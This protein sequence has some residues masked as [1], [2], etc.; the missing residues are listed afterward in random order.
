MKGKHRYSPTLNASGNVT[1]LLL[2]LIGLFTGLFYAILKINILRHVNQRALQQVFTTDSV[3]DEVYH[4]LKN[5][6]T[7]KFNLMGAL[8]KT[9]S[10]ELSQI[11]SRATENPRL[12]KVGTSFSSNDLLGTWE[13]GEADTALITLDEMTFF[14]LSSEEGILTLV[15]HKKPPTIG[16]SFITRSIKVGQFTGNYGEVTCLSRVESYDQHVVEEF[17]QTA[18]SK[19]G[20][21]S[22]CD[23]FLLGGEVTLGQLTTIGGRAKR[24]DVENLFLRS[25][26]VS[27]KTSIDG[28]VTNLKFINARSNNLSAK[29]A[30][31]TNIFQAS[32]WG[33]KEKICFGKCD[34]DDDSDNWH[35]LSATAWRKQTCGLHDKLGHPHY[36][37]RMKLRYISRDGTIS[38][39][40][41]GD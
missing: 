11:S 2:I 27:E 10:T 41:L 5:S 21:T 17:C 37:K 12:F 33:G 25:L 31:E 6:E 23:K 38:C 20:H 18:L 22:T 19:S 7:C 1:I 9:R 32:K 13:P 29:V 36:G 24:L 26:Q 4:L 28:D 16:S 15:F 8:T 3:A 30:F 34:E 14:P 35:C 40:D 39:G